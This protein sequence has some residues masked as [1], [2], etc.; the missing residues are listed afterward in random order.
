MYRFFYK[1]SNSPAQLFIRLALAVVMFPH[2]AQKV[3]GWFGGPGFAKTLQTFSGMG[4][5]AWSTVLLMITET[6][7]PLFLA[8]GLLT[9]LWALAIGTSITIC[10]SLYHVQH[11]F[12]MNWFG[13]QQG[14]GIEYHILVIGIALAL[15][16]SG[17]GM[18]SVDRYLGERY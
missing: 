4:F 15:V 12:F 14:E 9:R 2:G 6:L 3:F 11:G 13:K 18:L 10:M 16:V 5:P 7:G 8:F 1:T 17:G